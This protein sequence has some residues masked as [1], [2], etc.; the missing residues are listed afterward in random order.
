GVDFG[1]FVAQ[2]G[3]DEMVFRDRHAEVH[4][5]GYRLGV[6]ADDVGVARIGFAEGEVETAGHAVDAP[7]RIEI[8]E[9]EGAVDLAVVEREADALAAAEEIVLG[10]VGIEY[11]AGGL[12]KAE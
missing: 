4:A 11:D 1:R 5:A 9:A 10:H 6:V 12:R 2:P 7:V 8:P 3:V